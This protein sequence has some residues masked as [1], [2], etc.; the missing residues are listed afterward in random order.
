MYFKAVFYFY[1]LLNHL[2]SNTLFWLVCCGSLGD[3]IKRYFAFSLTKLDFYV[4][5]TVLFLW[6]RSTHVSTCT[7]IGN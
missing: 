1:L 5:F 7:P 3:I 2:I 4:D 6:E